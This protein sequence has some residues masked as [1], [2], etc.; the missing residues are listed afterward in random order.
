MV[1]LKK[2]IEEES[3]NQNSIDGTTNMKTY[4][5]RPEDAVRAVS[6]LLLLL[7]TIYYFKNEVIYIITLFKKMQCMFW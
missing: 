7:Y 1:A 5:L 6:C 4:T 2:A 3:G